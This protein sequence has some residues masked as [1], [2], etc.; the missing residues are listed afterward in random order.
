MSS[1]RDFVTDAG[2]MPI[3]GFGTWPLVG[4]EGRAAV[5]MALDAGYRHLDTAQAYENEAEVGAALAA[6]GIARDNVFIV[7]KVT[8]A[9]FHPDKFLASVRQSLERL[10]VD[11]VDLLLLH[12]PG[13]ERPMEE[14]L[15]LLFET[16]SAGLTAAVGVSNYTIDMMRAAA[17]RGPVATNQVEFHTQIDQQR[18]R[19][20][21]EGYGIQ[22]TAYCPLARGRI[23]DDP[24]LVD[25]AAETGHST[26]QI[27][28]RWIVQ[29][30]VAA[31]CMTRKRANAEANLAALS[32]TLTDAQ[33]ARIDEASRVHNR[34]VA[35]AAMDGVWDTPR[36]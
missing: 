6:S 22:L 19:E 30:G 16:K 27:A 32:F 9:N 14:T 21:A 29:K 36:A 18:L 1:Y 7:T 11:R 15:D 33:M 26:A 34:F 23:L 10:R 5:E 12:W 35:P 17:D 24:V 4:D 28:L 13:F 8:Q 25:I 3:L 20:A 2:P 31:I